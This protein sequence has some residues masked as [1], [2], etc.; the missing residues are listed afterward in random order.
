VEWKVGL[1][2]DGS[3]QYGLSVFLNG[4]DWTS[5]IFYPFTRDT[6]EASSVAVVDNEVVA[7]FA[8]SDLDGLKEP[9]TWSASISHERTEAFANDTCGRSEGTPD[10][11]TRYSL[12]L[13]FTE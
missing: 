6:A 12:P 8:L 1:Y 11:E 7:T 10:H 3:Y 13:A 4:A 9:T 2:Y 5:Q